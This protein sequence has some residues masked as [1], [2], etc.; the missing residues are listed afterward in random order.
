MLSYNPSP[1]EVT[2]LSLWATDERKPLDW[3]YFSIYILCVG[4]YIP[5]KNHN[6]R[7]V[8]EAFSITHQ[9]LVRQR[10]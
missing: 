5:G 2:Q 8:S 7:T 6:C 1:N 10:W 3:Q 9:W 4:G